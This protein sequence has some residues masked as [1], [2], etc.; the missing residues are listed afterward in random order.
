MI[1]VTGGYKTKLESQANLPRI[2]F[3]FDGSNYDSYVES[4]SSLRR[5]A[6]LTSGTA[7]VQVANTDQTWNIFESTLTN[8]GKTAELRLYFS[9]DS[10]YIAYFTGTVEKVRYEDASAYLYIRDKTAEMLEIP[11]G[12][13]LSPVVAMY[14]PL[15]PEVCYNPADMVWDLLTVYG[16]LDATA[17]SANVDIDYDAWSDWYDD[18]D[19]KNYCLRARFTGHSIRSALLAIAH[20]SNSYIWV[21]HAGKFDFAPPYSSA[22]QTFG[23]GDSTKVDLEISKEDILNDLIVYYGYQP[24]HATWTGTQ[25]DD[26]AASKAA[27]GDKGYTEESRIIWHHNVGSALSDA[28]YKVIGYKWPIKHILLETTMKGFVTEIGDIITVTESLKGLSNESVR[29]IEITSLNLTDGT[30]LLKGIMTT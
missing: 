9:G 4:V 29:I 27:Y 11:L 14:D 28:V 17:S 22:G 8:F 18:C 3:V 10:E 23:T 19:T 12:S 20:R 13:G 6:R 5:D 15:G 25:T 26:D 16:G 21:N 2:R 7:I 24:A 1:S 30:T